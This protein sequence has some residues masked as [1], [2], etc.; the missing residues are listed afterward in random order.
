VNEEEEYMKLCLSIFFFLNSLSNL[1]TFVTSENAIVM[2]YYF[3]IC[4]FVFNDPI[5]FSLQLSQMQTLYFQIFPTNPYF[6]EVT[7]YE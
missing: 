6:W 1:C 4:I 7:A 3:M 5:C 2:E